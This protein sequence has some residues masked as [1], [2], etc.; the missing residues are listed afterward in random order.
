M[1]AVMAA[2]RHPPCHPPP[3]RAAAGVTADVRIVAPT[4]TNVVKTLQLVIWCLLLRAVARQTRSSAQR[5]HDA[6]RRRRAVRR[7]RGGGLR[8]RMLPIMPPAGLSSVSSSS[9]IHRHGS[10]VPAAGGQSTK[11]RAA[12]AASSRWNSCGSNSAANARARSPSMRS[13][14][15]PNVCPTAKSSR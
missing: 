10:G 13:R 8:S 6:G 3:H 2:P 12:R 4:A 9:R 14:P 11:N 7:V 1:P 15:E 5:L